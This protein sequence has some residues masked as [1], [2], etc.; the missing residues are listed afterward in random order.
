MQDRQAKQ[1]RTLRL[2]ADD[3]I[4][5][6]VDGLMPETPVGDIT[7]S[8]RIPRGHKMA[9]AKIDKGQPIKKFGQIIGF[10]SADISPGQHVHTD[11]CA[12]AEFDR[13]YAFSQD[14]DNEDILPVEQRATF[15]GF[16]RASGKVGTRN[17]IAIL[18][19]V[20]CS[21]SVARFM[22][23]AVNRSGILEQFPNVDGVVSFVHGTGCGMAGDGEGL[24]LP[25]T[26]PVGLHRTPQHRS[27]ADRRPGLRG[28]PD[29]AHEAEIWVR[30]YGHTAHDDNPGLRRHPEDHRNRRRPH[31]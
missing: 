24:R 2:H 20:N 29:R 6:A 13:D 26:H 4:I 1:Q 27:L 14:A 18:T 23:E 7:A 11:N 12:Y 17:Y 19:S 15:E 8:A 28:L 30:R 10:A 9:I 3:N 25:G 21:A 22:A 31:H 16:R 5:V